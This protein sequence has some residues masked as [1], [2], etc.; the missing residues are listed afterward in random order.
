METKEKND[1][2]RMQKNAHIVA[3]TSIAFKSAKRMIMFGFEH[4]N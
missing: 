1:L 4:G 2:E 3:S